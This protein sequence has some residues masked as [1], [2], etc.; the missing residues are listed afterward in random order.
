[1]VQEDR[2]YLEKKK[3]EEKK[4][5]QKKMAVDWPFDY[6]QY[7]VGCRQGSLT[8]KNRKERAAQS[9]DRLALL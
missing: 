5:I 7:P 8:A 2:I 9:V 4:Q 1:M 6:L 3:N